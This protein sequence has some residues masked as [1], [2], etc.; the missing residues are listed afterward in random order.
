MKRQILILLPVLALFSCTPMDSDDKENVVV[1]NDVWVDLGLSVLWAKYNI[2]ATSPEEYGGYYAWG[3]TAGKG[4][5]T[6][7]NY[8]FKKIDDEK[9]SIS[10]TSNDVARVKWGGDS[11]MPE[12]D[13][14][15]ELCSLCLWEDHI[16]NGVNGSLVTGQNGNSI[17]IPDA[18]LR[19]NENRMPFVIFWSATSYNVANARS[20]PV[21]TPD[22]MK[23]S[24]WERA[25]GLPVRAVKD[26]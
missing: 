4:T 21:V 7:E 10:G 5:Y 23:R 15:E 20:L 24:Y 26:K 1:D 11:R 2:G 18:G 3:E 16:L 12:S 25:Y 6:A 13:E 17:F 9:F 19:Y 8:L 14:I 22:G